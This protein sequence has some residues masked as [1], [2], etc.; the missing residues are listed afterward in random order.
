MYSKHRGTHQNFCALRSSE[1]FLSPQTFSSRRLIMQLVIIR[2]AGTTAKVAQ[3]IGK[4]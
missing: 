3:I 4:G 2:H 1:V